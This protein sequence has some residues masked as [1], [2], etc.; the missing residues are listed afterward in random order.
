MRALPGQSILSCVV[1]L[2][3]PGPQVVVSSEF[4]PS[5]KPQHL[6]SFFCEVTFYR[7][8]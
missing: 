4:D 6:G 3:A 2:D 8:T 5:G 1:K 7:V